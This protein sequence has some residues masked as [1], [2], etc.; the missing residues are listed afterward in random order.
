MI[1]SCLWVEVRLDLGR[2]R[3]YCCLV[4]TCTNRALVVVMLSSHWTDRALRCPALHQVRL[5]SDWG[6]SILHP[7]YVVLR[8]RSRGLLQQVV[9]LIAQLIFVVE[10]ELFAFGGVAHYGIVGPGSGCGLNGLR[11]VELDGFIGGAT[12]TQRLLA[13]HQR[14]LQGRLEP[15]KVAV[16]RG[17]RHLVQSEL[18]GVLGRLGGVLVVLLIVVSPYRR[19]R[20]VAV[21]VYILIEQINLT[22]V[23]KLR[24]VVREHR[25][26]GLPSTIP[27]L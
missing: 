5:R 3:E 7:I 16:V 17:D 18:I 9:V 24:A 11:S 13:R 23:L 21:A 15:G 10:N 22:R 20:I 1:V 4:R 8:A 27:L 19:Q 14:R 12:Q 6:Q 26:H 25:I 2:G